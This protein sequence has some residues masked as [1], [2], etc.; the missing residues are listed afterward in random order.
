MLERDRSKG[1]LR[2][3][4]VFGWMD[5]LNP[6][7]ASCRQNLADPLQCTGRGCWAVAELIREEMVASRGEQWLKVQFC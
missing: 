5:R 6:G 1:V 2:G 7:P 4:D 3:V